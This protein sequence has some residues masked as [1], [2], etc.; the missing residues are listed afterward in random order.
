M[1]YTFNHSRYLVIVSHLGHFSRFILAAV[2]HT[3]VPLT[4]SHNHVVGDTTEGTLTRLLITQD[5]TRSQ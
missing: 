1:F 4:H 5:N 3:A 2:G